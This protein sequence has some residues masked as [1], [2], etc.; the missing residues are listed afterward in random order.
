MGRLFRDLARSPQVRARRFGEAR[1]LLHAAGDVLTSAPPAWLDALGGAVSRAPVPGEDPAGSS[2]ARAVGVGGDLRYALRRLRRE[3]GPAATAVFTLA[4]GLGANVALFSVAD[5]VLL[6][7]LPYPEPE[8]IVGLWDTRPADG[9]LHEHPSPGNFLDWTRSNASFEALAAWQDGSGVSTLHGEHEVSVVETVKVTPSFFRVLGAPP[10]LGRT[11]DDASEQGA[12]FDVTDRYSGGDRV[13]VLGHGLWTRRFGRD[14]GVVGRTLDLDGAPWR[15]VGVMPE[16]FALP[17]P[18]TEVF[19]PWDIGP[20]FAAFEG[21]P[22]RDL[23]F[24]NVLGRLRRGV[25]LTSAEAELQA[26]AARLAAEHPKANAG[27]SARLVPLREELA[28]GARP[29]VLLLALAVG[30]V[31]L[32]ACAN[33]A[34][35]QLA[36]AAGR[37][38]E[39]SVRL[40][41]GASPRRLLRQLLTESALLAFLGGLLG[42]AVA[43]IAQTLIV[44]LVP[45]ALGGL[46]GTLGAG[47]T[48][49]DARALL[50]A[51]GLSLGTVLL[52]GLVPALEASRTS[53]REALHDGGR[54]TTSGPRVRRLR[55][56]LVAFEVAAALVLLTGAGLLGRSLLRLLA[57]NTGFDPKD[58]VSL[59]VSLDHATYEPGEQSRAFYRDLMRRLADLPGV[60]AA[61]AV[62]AL[63]LHP[64]GTD[65]SR[66]YWREGEPDPGGAASRADIRMA[67]PGYLGALRM[68][69]RQGRGILETDTEAA[70]RVIVVNETLARQ[71]FGEKSPLGRRLMLDYLGGAYP[72][73]IVGLVGD[74]RFS[75]L[76]AA[77]RPELFI[78]HAQNPY[79]DLTVVVRGAGEATDLFRRVR[80]EIAAVDPRQAA[81]AVATMEELVRRSTEADRFAAALLLGLACLALVLAATGLHGLLA[82][83]V[84]QRTPE[85]GLRQALGATPGQVVTLV[86]GESLRPVLAGGAL[87]LGVLLLAAPRL[88]GLLFEVGARDVRVWALAAGVLLLVAFFASLI[89]ARA[90]A[91]KGPLAALRAE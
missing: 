7:P 77:P 75:S 82:Y 48:G 70:P 10:L 51:A 35:L 55:R 91:R 87:G 84:A 45:S 57:V 42:L 40:S 63:P 74:A 58:L 27:W 26:L 33:V 5:R 13:L 59:R 38:R 49:L 65:F 67:T 61:G 90:A 17:R 69:L 53:L 34:G 25:P 9:R 86:L 15:V 23:R 2:S 43:R 14:P 41:L 88:S 89:P 39:M 83:V 68:L 66:P 81:H 47:D 36:R 1:A 20:S 52:F 24:L 76:R 8:R 62:T 4:L 11:F 60:E 56:L 12:A 78:P 54:S 18:T 29:A 80:G 37:R 85:L 28:A 64:V 71:A 19:I 22:P 72:Y 46:A 50:F 21:G 73:E 32:L 44:A 30:L 6:R 3:P 31:L 79:L 16:S